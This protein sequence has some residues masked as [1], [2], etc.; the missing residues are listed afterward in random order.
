M[1][2]GN[3]MIWQDIWKLKLPNKEKIFLWRACHEILPT[4]VNLR[5]RKIIDVSLCPICEAADEI[6]VHALWQCPAATDVWCVG[7]KKLQKMS[8]ASLDFTQIV[9][10]V[11]EKCSTE[12]SQLFVGIARKIWMRRNDV[13]HGNSFAHPTTLVQC[14]RRNLEEFFQASEDN[15]VGSPTGRDESVRRWKAPPPGWLKANWDASLDRRHGKM[16]CGVVVRDDK[17]LV[18]AARCQTILGYLDPQLAEARAALMAVQLCRENGFM[19]VEFEGDAKVM[20]DA[21]NSQGQ[22]WSRLGEVKE[23]IRQEVQGLHN[24]RMLFVHR[25]CNQAAHALSK[26][27]I[28]EVVESQWLFEPPDCIADILSLK[29]NALYL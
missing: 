2:Q 1:R 19:S 24:W 23:D 18:I 8:L 27:A 5:R 15:P 14:A 20:I 7:D 28:C 17:G 21:V 16:G 12:E 9:T 22:D 10:I 3:N 6:V 25:E 13:I 4:R 26:T 29:R 11:F